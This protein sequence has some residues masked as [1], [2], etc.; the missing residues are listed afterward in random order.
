MSSVQHRAT[1]DL[2]DLKRYPVGD[3]GAPEFPRLVR[4]FRKRLAKDGVIMMPGFTTPDTTS[5]L[6]DEASIL[7]PGAYY[8][9]IRHNCY[10]QPADPSFPP[11]HPRNRVHHNN[12]GGVADD[13][14]P[15]S[16]LLRRI[17]D[18]A[19][20]RIFLAAVLDLD[21]LYPLADPLSSLNINV[22][23][24]GQIQGWH[25]D[26]AEFAV[27]LMLQ[28]AD[29]GGR[30]EYVLNLR[31]DAD[32]NFDGVAAILDGDR[33]RVRGV[34]IS[35][36]T[37][38]IFRGHHSLHQVTAPEGERPRINAIFSYATRQGALLHEHTRRLF[39]G[40]VQ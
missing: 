33:T 21:A 29:A 11:D 32:P 35:D 26:G 24:K 16:A 18:W 3:P 7:I 5:A 25:F 1:A 6:R 2:I 14:I 27:T 23:R 8:C 28:S 34:D 15:R 30:F 9:D 19:P 40:R 10:L 20:L 4:E 39:Y 12:K 38:T 31:S 22:H 17:Y 13:Q 36:G 37:L